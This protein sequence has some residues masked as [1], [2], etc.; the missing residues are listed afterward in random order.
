MTHTERRTQIRR[1][2]RLIKK[3]HQVL[4]LDEW[5]VV[6][7]YV[8]GASDMPHGFQDGGYVATTQANWQYCE[9][10]IRWDVR[11]MAELEDEYLEESFL[12]ECFHVLVAEIGDEP[13][14]SEERV[15]TKLARILMRV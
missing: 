3:W 10:V 1:I 2:N 7:E 4:G 6:H 8:D 15:V 5:R 13:H 12:H 9:A 14:G 11:V